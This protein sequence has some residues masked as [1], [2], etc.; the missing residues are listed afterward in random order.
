MVARKIRLD[1]IS[2]ITRLE[3]QAKCPKFLKSIHDQ[4]Q[5][6]LASPSFWMENLS[7]NSII[8]SSF[9]AWLRHTKEK[10]IGYAWAWFTVVVPHW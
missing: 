10:A 3:Y 7:T 4:P 5:R 2:A 8:L 6:F 1:F 9:D